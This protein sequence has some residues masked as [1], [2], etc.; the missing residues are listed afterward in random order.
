MCL[1]GKIAVVTGASRGLGRSIAM[2]FARAGAS[3]ALGARSEGLLK[4]VET[5]LKRRVCANQR[6]LAVPVD[7]S[8][9]TSIRHFVDVIRHAFGHIDILVNCAGVPGPRGP[10]DGVDWA[11]WKQAVEVNLLGLVFMTRCVLP[12]MR[13][14][15]GKIINISGGGATKPLPHLSAY[16]A[17]KAAVVRFTET[18]AEEVRDRMIDVN[19]VAPGVLATKM[20]EQFLEVEQD[21]LGSAYVEEVRRQMRNPRPALD[22]A[23]RLCLYLA[24]SQA[25]G[26]TGKLISAVWDPWPELAKHRAEL[27]RSDVYALR[28]ITPKDR[29]LNWEERG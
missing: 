1:R 4:R 7:V 2:H 13:R 3:V 10:V 16:A 8:S 15:R 29:G 12:L 9:E 23:A 25:D 20:V 21:V 28:R 18:L 26:I 11:E 5:D 6:I 14:R 17:T 24:S 19:A 27:M 22:R